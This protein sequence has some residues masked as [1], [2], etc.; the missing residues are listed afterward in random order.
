MSNS[1]YRVFVEKL[2]GSG[3]STTFVGN[4]GELFWDPTTTALKVSDGTTAGGVGISG[5]GGGGSSSSITDGTKTLNF[6]SN[7]KLQLDTDFLPTV[8]SDGTTGFDLGA[9]NAKWR[10]LYLSGSTLNLAGLAISVSNSQLVMPPMKLTG[11]LLPD[12]NAVYDLGNAEYKIRHL[13]LSDNSLWIGDDHKMDTKSG[14]IKFRK[15]KNDVVPST[16]VTA[17]GDEA[18]ALA[19]TGAGSLSDIT[20]SQWLAY[21]TS[22]DNTKTS[23]EDLYPAEGVGTGYTTSDYDSVANETPSH[24]LTTP[25]TSSHIKDFYLDRGDRVAIHN[26]FPE[27]GD[28]T[29]LDINIH[30]AGGPAPYGGTFEVDIWI[31]SYTMGMAQG[32]IGSLTIDGNSYTPTV[33]GSFGPSISLY[34]IKGVQIAETFW[35]VVVTLS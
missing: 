33:V 1:I 30:N 21:L 35:K 9:S 19:A 11:H 2:G 28:G 22:L 29:T 32:G 13:F 12:T 5:G 24:K 16:V 8:D 15:R 14:G 4:E 23:V 25:T 7:N 17:G 27:F 20:L 31:K 10:D 18:G 26:S 6:D 34:N 3:I